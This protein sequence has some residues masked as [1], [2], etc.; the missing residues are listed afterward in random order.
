MAKE[1]S[2]EQLITRTRQ[3]PRDRTQVIGEAISDK[4]GYFRQGRL[5]Q[6]GEPTIEK[7]QF[8][9]GMLSNACKIKPL[10]ITSS[11]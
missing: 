7:S 4:G 6:T 3:V 8:L 9:H 10:E 1:E 5:F 2:L 11:E